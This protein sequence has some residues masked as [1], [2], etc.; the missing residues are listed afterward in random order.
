M[1]N[2]HDS[3]LQE[4]EYLARQVS[5]IS[6]CIFSLRPIIF[7]HLSGT[8]TRTYIVQILGVCIKKGHLACIYNG[9][10]GERI[11]HGTPTCGTNIISIP[12]LEFMDEPIQNSCI[13]LIAGK[14]PSKNW[15]KAKNLK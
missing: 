1:L 14:G 10:N 9:K 11:S 3:F 4:M 15:Y 2:E 7:M 13:H 5:L 8:G 12:V 6:A